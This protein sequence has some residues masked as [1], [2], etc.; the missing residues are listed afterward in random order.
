MGMEMELIAAAT[1]LVCL[2]AF[3]ADTTTP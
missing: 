2:L 3:V 1:A